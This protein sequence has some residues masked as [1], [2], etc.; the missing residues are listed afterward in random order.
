[1][2]DIGRFSCFLVGADTLLIQCAESLLARGHNIRGVLSDEP[3]L[4]RWAEENNVL[5][6]TDDTAYMDIMGAE[7]FDYLLSIANLRV[8]PADWLAMAKRG[9]INFHDGPLPRYAGV[10]APAWALMNGEE[11]FGITWHLMTAGIDDGDIVVGERFSVANDETLLTLNAKC[12]DAAISSF[13]RLMDALEQAPLSATPQDASG[14]SYFGKHQR[15]PAGCVLDWNQPAAELER[16]V[17]ALDS[18]RYRN[19][20]GSPMVRH[21]D[22]VY[23]VTAATVHDSLDGIAAGSI[24]S[25]TAR[26]LLVTT[27]DATLGISGLA[28]RQGRQV[29]LGEFASRVVENPR[30][31]LLTPNQADRL[32]GLAGDLSRSEEIW[33]SRLAQAETLDIPGASAT[34]GMFTFEVLHL[35][36]SFEEALSSDKRSAALVSAFAVFVAKLTSTET[37]TLGFTNPRLRELAAGLELWLSSSVPMP[38]ESVLENG[39]D[40][41]TAIVAEE[42]D[43]TGQRAPWLHD[44]V[45]RYPQLR[46][47]PNLTPKAAVELCT[48]LDSVE[49]PTGT[50]LT[51]AVNT[52]S[53]D[54]RFIYDIAALSAA[55]I[56][57][58]ERQFASVLEQLSANP[59]R[60][61]GTVSLMSDSEKR[62]VLVDWN[63]T[64]A[65]YRTDICVHELI[66]EQVSR[67]PEAIAI[68]SAEQSLTYRELDERAT[69]LARRLRQLGIGP[70]RSVGVCLH[71]SLD[72]VVAILGVLKAGGAY[73]PIDPAMAPDRCQFILDDAQVS[74]LITEERIV[75]KL[76][77][78]AARVVRIDAQ[79]SAIAAL[80]VEDDDEVDVAPSNLAYTIYTSGSTGTPKGVMVEH[81]NVVSFFA[82]MDARI[83]HAT[84]D[85]WL[86]VTSLSFDISVLE[87][88]W[89]LTHGFKVIITADDAMT[90]GRADA[91]GRGMEMGLFFWGSDDGEGPE[92]YRLLLDCARFADDNGFSSVWTPERHFHAFGGPY[93]NPAVTSAAL[94]AIT[95]RVHIRAGC[96]VLPLHHPVRV[97]EEWAV[98]DNLSNGRVGIGVANGWMPNDFVLR[99]ETYANKKEVMFDEIETLRRLWRGESIPL[100]NGQG[101]I[102]NTLTLPRPIQP[103]VPI[104]ITTAGNP[105]TFRRAGEIGANLLTHLLGQTVEEVAEKIKTYRQ[106]RADHGHDPAAGQVTLML[107]TFVGENDDTVRDIVRGPMKEYLGSAVSLVAKH[108]WTF[109]TYQRPEGSAGEG[110]DDLTEQDIAS[111]SA[112][113]ADV[114]LEHAFD[115]YFESSG[116]FGTPETCLAMI[117]K[118]KAIDVDEI[119]CL[120]DYGVETSTVEANLHHL[121]RLRE[122]ANAAQ[123]R[124]GA[125]AP[126]IA[127][128]IR[129]HNVTHVQCTPSLARLLLA[130]DQVVDALGSVQ[131]LMVGGE[132]L[133][134]ELARELDA[135]VGGT[136]TNMYGPT[137]T[138]IWSSTHPAAGAATTV[139]I[140]RP[141]ANS[142]FYVLDRQGVPVPIGAPGELCI[143]GPGVAR[144]YVDRAEL[145]A[146]RFVPDPFADDGARMYRTGDVARWRSDGVCEF[147]GRTDFQLKIRGY[148]VEPGE[149]EAVLERHPAV[150][151]ALVVPN[152]DLPG[153][154][155]LIA[156]IAGDHVST[157]SLRDHLRHKLPDYMVPAEFVQLS[158]FPMTPSGKLDR[159]ALPAPAD[160]TTAHSQR[161]YVAPT[162]DLERQV[163]EL[164]Q[165]TLGLPKVGTDDNFFDVGGHSLLIVR[166]HRRLQEMVDK[167]V[168]LT[169]LYRFPTV[170]S[171]TEYLRGETGGTDGARLGSERGRRRQASL[172]RRAKAGR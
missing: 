97:A 160:S 58:M 88:L 36:D 39:F 47:H 2:E 43:L 80:N 18:G 4:V 1:M 66:A 120:M 115:R 83:P 8:L 131:Q 7:D 103:E 73:V 108:A 101:E 139:P 105:D 69:Q 124:A 137:E 9:S 51:L 138:T 21:G 79:W 50:S 3:R 94:A 166:L 28:T 99:P 85:T 37:V 55:S 10:N 5:A 52:E 141:I 45:G 49:P 44:M 53:G 25:S 123:T 154:M 121:A 46:S 13:P 150:R 146:D 95:S 170:R 42:V 12:F 159:Q 106:A 136:V 161:N 59:T 11:Q 54:C 19:P 24:A 96:V 92:K 125:G 56:R 98:V 26:E 34:S 143:G 71:R 135:A 38:L 40:Q 63:D 41:L 102:S 29:D 132:A 76:P 168:A 127:E 147:L 152:E 134:A 32:T 163:A 75:P 68:V 104:W 74:V 155:R 140:G 110:I 118:L 84:G 20:L 122:L 6:L 162:N 107:H 82:G 145:T 113:E 17:R 172:K 31:E 165:E 65:D 129:A 62:Q 70:D 144:G 153:D 23:V 81:G 116:L 100:E 114:I 57:R 67:T 119:G 78:H 86:A 111:L 72:V 130:D 14:R 128:Q 126:S 169:D 112:E 133:S 89:T 158:H 33:V 87:L 15:P 30:F 64:A 117:D 93:P 171:L 60:S 142:T 157:G 156:Y 35:P 167:P 148:R 27:G 151:Q 16:L 48:D 164:W 91:A 61:A 149:I 90:S 77:E 22:D 109:P